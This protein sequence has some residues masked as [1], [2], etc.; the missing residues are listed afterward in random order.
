MISISIPTARVN[1]RKAR[2][3]EGRGMRGWWRI[4]LT[5]MDTTAGLLIRLSPFAINVNLSVPL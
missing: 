2:K 4:E 5:V 1:A 3:T